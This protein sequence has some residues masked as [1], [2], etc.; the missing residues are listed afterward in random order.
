[1]ATLDQ[2]RQQFPSARDLSDNEIISKLSERSGLPYERVAAQ[3][4]ITKDTSSGFFGGAQDV[5]IEAANAAAGLVGSAGEF[6]S[7][8]NR[9]SAAI[10]ENIIEPGE[11]RQT[12]PT[13][14]AKRALAR[15]LESSE[16]VPQASAVYQYV[17]E[18]PLLAAGQALGSF[19]PIGLPVRG[20]TMAARGLGLGERA[21]AR[22]GLGTGAAVSGAAGGGDAANAAYELVMNTPREVL[23]SHP[24]AQELINAGVTDETAIYEEL[25]TRA[26]RRASVAPALIGAVAGATGAERLI[27]APVQGAR[28]AAVQVGLEAGTEALE[29]GATTYS[30]RRAAQEYNP[31][32]NPLAGVYGSALLGGVMGAGTAAP[33]ALVTMERTPAPAPGDATDLTSTRPAVVDASP[34]AYSAPVAAERQLTDFDPYA[35]IAARAEAGRPMSQRAQEQLLSSYF[36][37]QEAGAGYRDLLA[38]R[39][40]GLE[41]AQRAGEEYQRMMVR[42]GDQLLQA[43]DVGMQARPLVQSLQEA[44]DLEAAQLAA[45]QA[46]GAGVQNLPGMTA[47]AGT[48]ADFRRIMDP[49]VMQP[50]EPAPQEPAG[51]TSLLPTQVPFSNIR[52]DR[53]GPAPATQGPVSRLEDRPVAP[54]VSPPGGEAAVMPSA[55]QPA[56][57]AP[58]ID[59]KQDTAELTKLIQQANRTNTGSA[60]QASTQGQG[61]VRV[62][63]KAALTTDKLRAVRNALLSPEGAVAG[64]DPALQEVADS[65]RAFAKAYSD[66]EDAGGNA[67]RTPTAKRQETA[68]AGGQRRGAAITAAA[69]NARAALERVGA[70]VNNNAKDVEAVVSLVKT[71]VQQKLH[72]QQGDEAFAKAFTTMDTMLSR[73]WNAAKQNMFRGDTD[74][75][76]VRQSKTDI[77]REAKQAGGEATQLEQAAGG[78]AAFGKGEAYSGLMGILT[79]LRQSGTPMER[80]LAKAVRESLYGGANEP[81]LE[82]ITEGN[83]RYDPK[84]NTV[85]LH[86]DASPAVVLH[87]ALH[88]ALQRYIYENQGSATV[89]SLLRSLDAVVSYK[90]QLTGAAKDVQTLLKKLV[91]EGNTLDAALELVSYGNTLNDFRKALDAMELE[92]APKSFS[93]KVSV[94]WN[95]LINAVRGMLGGRRSVA[96]DVIMDSLQL[97]R[98]A[99]TAQGTQPRAG[100]VLDAAIQSEQQSL[101]AAGYP[102]LSAWK[103][104]ASNSINVT[105]LLFERM[106]FGKNGTVDKAVQARAKKAADFVRS[107]LPGLEKVIRNVYANFGLGVGFQRIRDFYRQQS[108]AGLLET[109][110]LVEYLHRHPADA[111]AVLDYLDGDTTAMDGLDKGPAL[112]AIADTVKQQLDQYIARLPAED[113]AFFADR[114]LTDFLLAPKEFS[115]LAGKSFGLRA[116]SRLIKPETRTEESIED[117]KQYLPFKD[118]VL[119]TDAALYQVFET[120]DAGDGKMVRAPFGFISKEL[121]ETNPPAGLDIDRDRIWNVT[122]PTKDTAKVFTFATRRTSGADLRALA[123]SLKDA[124]LSEEQ[125]NLALRQLTAALLNTVSAMSQN[126]AARN[127]VDSLGKL[128]YT[129]DKPSATSVVFDDIATI[130]ATFPGR[131]LKE[132]ELLDAGA[133]E[134]KIAGIKGAAQKTGVWVRI[135]ESPTYGALGGKIVAGPAWSSIMDMHDRKP[136]LGS[137]ALNTVMSSFKKAKTVYSPATHANNILTNYSMLLL[138]GISHKALKDAAT[139]FYKFQM[140]PKSLDEKQ[141]AIVQAF[142]RSGAVLGQ[143]TNTEAKAFI[144]D[145]LAKHITPDSDRS[146]LTKLLSLS[147]FEKN[148]SDALERASRAG[149]NVDSVASE[150][151]AAGDNVFRLAAFMQVAGNL[152]SREGT[153]TL[154]ADQ[155]AEA[156]LAA[157]KMFLDYD[158]DSRW[159]KA[160]RQSLFPFV[161]WSYAIM[162]VLGRLAIDKP[163]TIVN[164]MAAVALMAALTDGDDDEWRENGPEQVRDTT[165]GV[166]KYIR[167]PFLGSDESPVYW[168]IGKSIPMLSLLEPSP[169]QAKLA[170][171]SWIPGFATPGGPFVSLVAAGVYGIDPFTGKKLSDVTEEDHNRLFDT[172]KAVWD[173]MAP[174]LLTSRTWGQAKDVLQQKQ[175]PTGIDPDAL[176]I[177]RAFGL[178]LYEFNRS[179]VEF[180]QDKEVEKLKREFTIVMNKA[181]REEMAKGY[182]DYEALD[183]RLSELRDKMEKRIN[184]VRGTKE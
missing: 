175:G 71:M 93:D 38:G 57:G 100:N 27:A 86:R 154:T 136:L 44:A 63:G 159:V 58:S 163:W 80:L 35:V 129:G 157:R 177:A 168:N 74:Q 183:E 59:E 161:S 24:Q 140:S 165:L 132:D 126:Y 118:G 9:V 135:P 171:Q 64:G 99:S 45:A 18:N 52:M 55:A 180:Y 54:V 46:A 123:G 84:T 41:A 143:Y 150:L 2:I 39:D 182:P 124:S 85:Y 91:S 88:A 110:F 158:I 43:Q 19:A 75:L 156:G 134:A 68:I 102:D 147:K 33:I 66:F 79:S 8:G 25:A 37:A 114:K 30:G 148:F 138:H 87:E 152:Q 72:L 70:A 111:Q 145:S 61:V 82:F 166:P 174:G 60:L 11:A 115:Q 89:K 139:L 5:V 81:K 113:Q 10:R 1:M 127:L 130:N 56:A 162:P 146:M 7:P 78:S 117:F 170:G 178:S 169:G 144:A 50:V 133:D 31:A 23:L 128:G 109:E 34:S 13:Q 101:Q 65:V 49:R 22:A 153:P 96:T 36:A 173:T 94:L 107:E 122:K 155:E 20:A 69:N 125:R 184:E 97:L 119:D 108:Q 106:G 116:L 6:I 98:E 120:F 32:I 103:A 141:L 29:E 137:Q 149:K 104:P 90:G 73:G 76:Y 12:V 48:V 21:A 62:P 3:F 51:R 17:T 15:G 181:K 28:R 16:F 142:F 112:K 95:S 92:G 83:N 47:G 67:V 164:M 40:R 131:N 167:V 172:G 160:A 151:Y 179:E 105:R 4:G 77:S 176:F 42:R 26:A 53:P 14:L 121:A